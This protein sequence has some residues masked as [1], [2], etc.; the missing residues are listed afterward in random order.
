MD[1]DV[2][3]I[4][5]SGL[6]WHSWPPFMPHEFSYFSIFFAL[7]RAW[8]SIS[9]ATVRLPGMPRYIRLLSIRRSS[10]EGVS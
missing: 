9:E 8:T 6:G 10:V 7:G 2:P 3:C 1:K 5:Y 4:E